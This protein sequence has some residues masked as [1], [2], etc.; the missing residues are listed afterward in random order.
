[1]K[2]YFIVEYSENGRHARRITGFYS[3]SV[4]EQKAKR[5]SSSAYIEIENTDED[6]YGL[7]NVELNEWID[8]P[9]PRF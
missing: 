2:Q 9:N 8:L 5:F 6:F 3:Y 7:K 4:I 1:M